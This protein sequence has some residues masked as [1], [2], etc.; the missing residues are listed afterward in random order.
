[1]HELYIAQSILNSVRKSLPADVAPERVTE[2][3]V[4][5]GELDAVVPDT[6]TFLFDAIK[7]DF[8]MPSASL[9]IDEI[10]VRCACRDCGEVFSLELPIFICPKCR[11]G[12]VEVLQGRGIK[13]TGIMAEDPEEEHADP[14]HS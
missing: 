3:R 2:V 13:L 10:P 7:T 12:R 9:A 6:L 5:V 11:S 8:G 1:M 14:H 4:E